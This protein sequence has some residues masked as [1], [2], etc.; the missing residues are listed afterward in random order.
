MFSIT[1]SFFTLI[2]Q[3]EDWG[4]SIRLLDIY[5]EVQSAID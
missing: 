4:W 5:S 2:L 3:S 1:V